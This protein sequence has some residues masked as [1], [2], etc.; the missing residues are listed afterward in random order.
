MDVY[1]LKHSVGHRA[2]HIVE[3]DVNSVGARFGEGGRNV[4]RLVVDTG[5]ESEFVYDEVNL[6]VAARCSDDAASHYLAYLPDH[7]PDCAGS[8]GHDECIANLRLSDVQKTEVGGH[9]RHTQ[10]AH[11]R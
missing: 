8:G 1:Q 2:A 9:A 3:I 7:L 4:L 10:D 11:G 5:V 6:V